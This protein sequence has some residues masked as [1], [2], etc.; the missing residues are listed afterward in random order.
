[1]TNVALTRW[2]CDVCGSEQTVMG[3]RQSPPEWT[4]PTRS[5]LHRDRKSE[6]W[7]LGFTQ[8]KTDVCP[9]CTRETQ[10]MILAR[11]RK[12]ATPKETPLTEEDMAD[13]RDFQSRENKP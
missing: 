6:A 9:A 10:E 8:A 11:A 13:W 7:L 3:T 2:M 4:H 1:M 12:S 5:E